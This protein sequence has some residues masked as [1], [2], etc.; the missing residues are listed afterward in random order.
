M[1]RVHLKNIKLGDPADFDIYASLA[2]T[3]WL[4]SEE[5]AQSGADPDKVRWTLGE[6]TDYSVTIDLW[7]YFE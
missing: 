4:N 6:P 1:K 5:F 3:S 2:A 7:E